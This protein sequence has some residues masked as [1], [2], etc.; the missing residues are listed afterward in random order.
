MTT[1]YEFIT[2]NKEK[3]IDILNIYIE[4]DSPVIKEYLIESLIERIKEEQ[5]ERFVL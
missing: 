5:K 3:L 1:K 2:I 4:A